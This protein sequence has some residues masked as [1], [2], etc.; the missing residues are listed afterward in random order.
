MWGIFV[1]EAGE[2]ISEWEEEIKRKRK[3]PTAKMRFDVS[4]GVESKY[5]K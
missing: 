4:K 1:G 3:D 5:P 2:W